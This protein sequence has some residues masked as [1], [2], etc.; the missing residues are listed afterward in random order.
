MNEFILGQ[1]VR[2]LVDM[3]ND[4]SDVGLGVQRCANKG[5]LLVVRRI[6]PGIV[7]SVIVSHEDVTD[8]AFCASPDELELN[9]HR[10]EFNAC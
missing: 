5:D 10:K 4:L 7:N 3:D 1:R 2:A 8:R 6:S 9:D